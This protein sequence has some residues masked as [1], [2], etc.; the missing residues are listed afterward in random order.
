[1][2]IYIYVYLHHFISQLKKTQFTLRS[3]GF[4]ALT[5]H[6]RLTVWGFHPHS[7]I[8]S[9]GQPLMSSSRSETQP[10]REQTVTGFH[11]VSI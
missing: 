2:N 1:M 8:I 5:I 10:R 9:L 3:V 11:M 4:I 6:N 7:V